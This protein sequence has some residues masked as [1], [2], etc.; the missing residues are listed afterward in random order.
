ML[1]LDMNVILCGVF[2][3]W[4][5]I[6]LDLLELSLSKVSCLGNPRVLGNTACILTM[7]D[8][9]DD[10]GFKIISLWYQERCNGCIGSCTR[11]AV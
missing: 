9:I 8:P 1:N 2:I 10:M 4:Y 3:R 7:C 5:S 6:H 11:Q